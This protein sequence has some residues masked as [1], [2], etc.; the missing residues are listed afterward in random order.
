MPE[1][2]EETITNI[3][4]YFGDDE[5]ELVRRIVKAAKADYSSKRGT[6]VKKRLVDVFK[7][8]D[9]K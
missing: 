6:W 5:Q 3:N 4:L 9:A 7:A 2:T 8:E 1:K